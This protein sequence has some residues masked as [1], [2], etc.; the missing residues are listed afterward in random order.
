MFIESLLQGAKT[1]YRNY[2]ILPSVTIAQAILESGWG[3]SGLTKIS[4]NLFG[5]KWYAGCGY[6]FVPYPTKEFINGKMI[7][8][9]ANFRKYAT[10]S[11]SLSDHASFL[12]ATRYNPVRV[13]TT[14]SEQ[15]K[16]LQKCGYATDPDYA[17]KLINIIENNKLFEYDKDEDEDILTFIFRP[18]E[19]KI[20][21]VNGVK[22]RCIITSN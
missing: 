4:N 5:I 1:A 20:I 3:E 2:G 7:E 10:L 17:S 11:D 6:E 8:V 14:Y 9:T 12:T 16:Q 22:I 13:A 19:T 21:D 15:C 18:G